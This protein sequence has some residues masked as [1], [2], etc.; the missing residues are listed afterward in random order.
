MNVSRFGGV[1]F[2]ISAF[3]YLNESDLE[4]CRPFSRHLM[5]MSSCFS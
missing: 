2:S 5:R 3:Y 4:L 1:G